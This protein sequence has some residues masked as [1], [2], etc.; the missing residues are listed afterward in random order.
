MDT[1]TTILLEARHSTWASTLLF[2]KQMLFDVLRTPTFLGWK[3]G[4][5]GWDPFITV[6]FSRSQL[7]SGQNRK[8]DVPLP[9]SGSSHSGKGSQ[10]ANML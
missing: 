1:N 7:S 5:D 4:P 10:P 8:A 6:T 2:V 3:P 9:F